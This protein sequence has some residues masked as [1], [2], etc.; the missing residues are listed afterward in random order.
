MQAWPPVGAPSLLD[1]E[2][3]GH[4][5]QPKAQIG[6]DAEDQQGGHGPVSLTMLA[7]D[8]EG[9]SWRGCPH[10]DDLICC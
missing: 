7:G 4:M 9:D 2:R 6:V 10:V 8:G 5:A 3:S 1:G